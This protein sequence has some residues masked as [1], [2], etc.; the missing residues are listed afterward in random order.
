MIQ[1]KAPELYIN[2]ENCT[3]SSGKSISQISTNALI[4]GGHQ[5][6][7]AVGSVLFH[8]LEENGVLFDTAF[9]SGFCTKQAIQT[10]ANRA[11]ETHSGVV[12]GV[13]G[14]SVLDIAKAVA[15]DAHLPVVTIPTIAATCAAWSA[16]SVIYDESGKVID[17]RLLKQAPKIVFADSKILVEAP[18]RYLQSGIGDTIVKW[19]E[20]APN[21]KNNEYDPAFQISLNTA[22]YALEVL[23]THAVQA[24][25]DNRQKRS[26][27]A[28]KEVV[29]AVIAL[30]GLVGSVNSGRY[31]FAA[32]HAIHDSMTAVSETHK[33]LHGEKV[34]FGLIAQFV[35]ERKSEPEI[36]H[37]IRSLNE[38]NLPVTLKQVG[39]DTNFSSEKIKQ[40]ASGIKWHQEALS[41]LEFDIN[42]DLVEEA[43]KKA[44]ELGFESLKV[45]NR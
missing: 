19:Y 17:H 11:V 20:Y 31:R 35:L 4:I 42:Q 43:I 15:E 37:L 25:E 44:D 30:A 8:S 3:Q 14:G 9:Y 13:G 29:D 18:V 26:S 5:A 23:E 2:E 45:I 28:F 24:V 40:I 33:S 6:L 38:L 41:H 12:I 10:F 32:A 27:K 34:I 22:K 21:N 36:T 1:I 39:I 16:L 7:E